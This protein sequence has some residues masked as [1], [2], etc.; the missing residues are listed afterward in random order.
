MRKAK[1]AI[2]TNSCWNIYN[3]RKEWINQLWDSGH[4]II[5]ISPIDEYF[6]CIK[7]FHF[8]N[9][10]P[11]KHL[12]SQGSSLWQDVLFL[13]ELYRI[14]KDEKPDLIFHFTIKLNI[15]GSIA[16][17][18]LKL[19]CVSTITG[20]GYTFRN[21][22]FGFL[23]CNLYKYALSKNEKIV[24]HNPDDRLYFV[25]NKLVSFQNTLVLPGSGINTQFFKPE[26]EQRRDGS[27]VFLFIGRLLI[28]KGLL[29]F[30]D[31]AKKAKQL[32]SNLEFWVLGELNTSNPNAVSEHELKEWE[33][34]NTI[35]YLG[36]VKDVRKYIQES[37]V[38]VLPSYREGL[39]RSILEAMSMEKA[40]IVSDV[41][42][43]RELVSDGWNGML[44]P[45]KNSQLLSERLLKMADKTPEQRLEMG[46]RGRQRILEKY[47]VQLVIKEYENIMKEILPSLLYTADIN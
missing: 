24:F 39:P 4:Q 9:H 30:V 14:Y 29:E 13:H 12:H 5:L 20:L 31:A 17:G 27:C 23:I 16:A 33:D 21:G 2:V 22:K 47:D 38:V 10:I 6:Q 36:Q 8:S 3:F 44:V 46:K 28:D 26:H 40:V 34:R 15:Y 43:C 7:E 1:I 18:F 41:P 11:L 25:E 35:R 19:K 45:A 32:N 37:D 42:G